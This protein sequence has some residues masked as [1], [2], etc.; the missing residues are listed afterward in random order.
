MSHS[1]TVTR[2]IKLTNFCAELPLGIVVHLIS[3]RMIFEIIHLCYT[4]HDDTRIMVY[5]KH[6]TSANK[7]IFTVF[8]SIRFGIL[9]HPKIW[10]EKT[11]CE[12]D[13]Q[14]SM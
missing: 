11:G 6:Y 10:V 5:F 4:S 12:Y 13:F 8:E 2:E 1:Y 7:N 14:H 3:L 9:L